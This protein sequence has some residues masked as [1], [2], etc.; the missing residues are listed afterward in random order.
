MS[1][2][3]GSLDRDETNPGR[4]TSQRGKNLDREM[5]QVQIV[6]CVNV[7]PDFSIPSSLKQSAQEI[8]E[9]F[10]QSGDF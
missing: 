6:A 10:Q 3:L 1:C 4:S 7:E 2:D 5:G 8:Q 9:Q